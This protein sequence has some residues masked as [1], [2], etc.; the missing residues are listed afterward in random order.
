LKNQSLG[1]V[2]PVLVTILSLRLRVWPGLGILDLVKVLV[3]V[4]PPNPVSVLRFSN[5]P[6]HPDAPE[7]LVLVVPEQAVVLEVQGALA[8]PA[9]HLGVDPVLVVAVVDPA[10][11]PRARLVA[12]A[13]KVNRASRSGRSAKSLKCGKHRA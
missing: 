2:F 3:L 10:V 13:P 4:D 6:A 12:V 5:V 7:H 9:A 11:V 8:D 1:R